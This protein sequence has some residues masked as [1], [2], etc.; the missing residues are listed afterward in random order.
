MPSEPM[1]EAHSV[2]EGNLIIDFLHPAGNDIGWHWQ[3]GRR[4]CRVRK[5]TVDPGER[6]ADQRRIS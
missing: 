1:V 4:R 2:E 3:M 5:A 6:Q